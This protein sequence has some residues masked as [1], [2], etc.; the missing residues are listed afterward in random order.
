MIFAVPIP[1]YFVMSENRGKIQSQNM[2][3]KI[4][5]TYQTEIGAATTTLLV[6]IGT[7]E[8]GIL[9]AAV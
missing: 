6:I 3:R 9:I 4:S 1:L 5:A 2:I 7:F 8:P